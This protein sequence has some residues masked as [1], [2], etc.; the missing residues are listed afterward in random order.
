[1]RHERLKPK[2]ESGVS[3]V[4]TLIVVVI[5]AIVAG[6]ALMQSNAPNA[7][8]KRQNV[9]RELKVAM[10]RARFDS[11]KRRGANSST[12]AM[13]YVTGTSFTL[14]TDN[15]L[16]GTITS[17]D[18]V[19]TNFA[20]QNIV[21]AGHSGTS[22]PT[23]IWFNQ[24]GEPVNSGGGLISPVFLVCNVS[25][26]SPSAANANIV[27]LTPTGTVNMLPGGATVPNFPVPNVTSVPP[28]SGISNIVTVP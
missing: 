17:A 26:S 6:L 10:E 22:V 7:Q 25:C 27:V 16:S 8:L 4:E 23:T 28:G 14:T 1:M 5:I 12:Q 3:L 21:I 20:A 24:R 2:L 19:M 13:L 18:D 15:D 11:V 9:A